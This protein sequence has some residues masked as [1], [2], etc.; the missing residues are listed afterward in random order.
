LREADDERLMVWMAGD[1][2]LAV[3]TGLLLAVTPGVAAA[4]SAQGVV[5]MLSGQ[6]TVARP[7]QPHGRPL[8]PRDPLF[9]RDRIDTA[10][11]SLLRVLLGGKALITV[12]ELSTLMIMEDADASS[13]TLSDGKL[14]IAVARSRMRPGETLEVHTP[15]AVA[16]VRG[17]VFVVEVS[18]P[19][20]QG[21][22]PGTRITV[23]RGVVGVTSPARPARGELLV[24]AGRRYDVATDLVRVLTPSE[25]TSTFADLTSRSSQRALPDEWL[26]GLLSREVARAGESAARFQTQGPFDPWPTVRAQALERSP[27]RAITDSAGGLTGRGCGGGVGGGA[28]VGC[29]GLGQ[30]ASHGRPR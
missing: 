12:R 2:S 11:R 4:Q 29:R 20:G 25:M 9:P 26:E 13:L 24:P 15:D 30:G 1:R 27:V 28:G 17:T 21:G 18:S 19:S 3:W 22:T 10:E 6:A 23:T 16:A 5:A 7:S 8:R 14:A